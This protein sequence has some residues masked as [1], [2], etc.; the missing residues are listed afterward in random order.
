MRPTRT[1]PKVCAATVL[2]VAFSALYATPAQAHR[3]S[4][5]YPREWAVGSDV[6]YGFDNG[7]P[8]GSFRFR[9]TDGK[10]EWNDAGGSREPDFSAFLADDDLLFGS[11]CFSP[12]SGILWFNRPSGIVGSVRLCVTSSGEAVRFSLAIDPDAGDGSGG[13]TWYTGTG[14]APGDTMDLWSVAAHEFGHVTGW[15]GHFGEDS[16]LCSNNSSRHTMCP[17]IPPG[18]QRQRTL[19]SHD[20][21][22]FEGAY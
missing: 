18:T 17:V 7:Y 20:T 3:A 13:L 12:N 19:Q 5:F 11:P 10:N 2:V 6:Q 16:S 21:H 1:I 22:T 15:L 14:D 4:T 8:S 9:T